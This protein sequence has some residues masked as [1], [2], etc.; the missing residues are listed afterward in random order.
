MWF[1]F[2]LFCHC[3]YPI[4]GSVCTSWPE[5]ILHSLTKRRNWKEKKKGGRRSWQGIQRRP[6]QHLGSLP[7]ERG[8]HTGVKEAKAAQGSSRGDSQML[9]KGCGL[10]V[11]GVVRSSPAPTQNPTHTAVEMGGGQRFRRKLAKNLGLANHKERL[12]FISAVS[13]GQRPR[14]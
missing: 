1:L 12:S 4:P 2:F 10:G 6:P 7:G 5:S 13:E 3:S 9:R 8:E 14:L 11:L